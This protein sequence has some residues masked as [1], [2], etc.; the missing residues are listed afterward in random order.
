MRKCSYIVGLMLFAALLFVQP[1]KADSMNINNYQL[2]GNGWNITFSLPQTLTP[3]SMTW[4]GIANFSNVASAGGYVFNAVQIGNA[5]SMGTNYWA[6]GSSTKS[7]ELEAPGLLTRNADGTVT[8]GFGTF[9]LGDYKMFQGG[10]MQY[11]LTIIDPPGT[12]SSAPVTTP[13]P[14]SLI[15]LGLGGLSLRAFRRKANQ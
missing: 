14:A 2:T 10:P 12:P 7:L 8:L 13:E 5:G 9:T 4:N 6:F 15:L 3:S 1:S 11:T